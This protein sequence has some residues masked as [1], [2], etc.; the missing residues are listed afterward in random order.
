[1]DDNNSA[2]QPSYTSSIR[3]ISPV[4]QEDNTGQPQIQSQ[5][6]SSDD[7]DKTDLSGFANVDD[8]S[9]PPHSST[10]SREE[11]LSSAH[12]VASTQPV[13]TASTSEEI[14][15]SAHSVSSTQ[16]V[17]TT[18]TSEE[19]PS[20]THSVSSTQLED[21]ASASEEILS[22]AHS[23]VSTQPV[24]TTSTS[25][26]LDPV[27]ITF[28]ILSQLCTQRHCS[29]DTSHLINPRINTNFWSLFD[30]AEIMQDVQTS[31]D[32]DGSLFMPDVLGNQGLLQRTTLSDSFPWQKI[33]AGNGITSSNQPPVLSFA[34]SEV[35]PPLTTSHIER[36][37]DI[38]SIIA[39]ITSLAAH[40]HGFE[41]SYYPKYSRSISGDLHVKINKQEPRTTKHLRLGHGYLSPNFHT[42]IMFPKLPYQEDQPTHLSDEQQARWISRIVL[43]S[44]VDVCPSHILHHHPRSWQEAYGKANSL[45]AESVRSEGGSGRRLLDLHYHIPAHYLETFWNRI[46]FHIQDEA[47]RDFSMNIFESPVL[48]INAYDLKLQ[49]RQDSFD[50]CREEFGIFLENTFNW[51]HWNNNQ[52]WVDVGFEDVPSKGLSSSSS[53]PL[54]FLRRRSCLEH[55]IQHLKHSPDNALLSSQIYNWN[56]TAD[57]GSARIKFNAG[58]HLR[59]G[60]VIFAQSYNVIKNL[61]TTSVKDHLP[62][63]DP[64]LE[65]LGMGKEVLQ[66]WY[67]MNQTGSGVSSDPLE[68]LRNGFLAMKRQ[69]HET[70]LEATHEISGVREEYRITYNLFLSLEIPDILPETQG[71]FP[72]WVLDTRDVV[73]FMRWEYNRWIFPIEY[74][75]SKIRDHPGIAADPQFIQVENAAMVNVLLRCLKA[76]SSSAFL[77]QK[78]ELYR[79]HYE[80]LHNIQRTGLNMKD[81]LKDFGIVWLPNNLFNWTNLGFVSDML[82]ETTFVHNGLR[83]KFRNQTAQREGDKAAE[84]DRGLIER[85][86]TLQP[87][88]TEQLHNLLLTMQ[89]IVFRGYLHHLFTILKDHL[90]LLS[91]QHQDMRLGYHGL[92]Y[93]MLEDILGHPPTLSLP[94]T[95]IRSTNFSQFP[96]SWTAKLQL[97]FD[98]DD[99]FQRT[100]DK[101]PYRL[102]TRRFHHLLQMHVGLNAAS[103][104]RSTL[105]LNAQRYIFIIPKYDGNR[106]YLP[107]KISK[108]HSQQRK[109]QLMD[110]TPSKRISWITVS[111]TICSGNCLSLPSFNPETENTD[112]LKFIDAN[113]IQSHG[114]LTGSS[115]SLELARVIELGN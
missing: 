71:Q 21:T 19:I 30:F 79:H 78:S 94:R 64:D 99:G 90:P 95:T 101:L 23:V 67:E 38:D 80:G 82:S 41:L 63:A 91:S 60:G 92:G 46:L 57:A 2:S 35:S 37:W 39:H 74:L 11:I 48:F 42:Y 14:P 32:V 86:R 47:S 43:P 25:E 45:R 1:M 20:S 5:T 77:P 81:S 16:P 113:N 53:T 96:H 6:Q 51:Q 114:H 28:S 85:M 100:W 40:S 106:L 31:N 52:T 10:T 104:Y 9:S 107:I 17:N 18:S 12:S 108:H 4:P 115:L 111:H 49:T 109:D 3:H 33:L 68:P 13:N 105:G 70:L 89:Q 93:E 56:L 62:F 72:Y 59:Q 61:F 50:L 76:S 22:L 69:I 102:R 15:S 34:A 29:N 66:S 7:R 27:T 73:D 26:E 84:A 54:T 88:D 55:W 44:L 97:L 103:L 112:C 58:H 8:F 24:D 98:W 83:Q 110:C 87:G 36:T 65:G 75:H